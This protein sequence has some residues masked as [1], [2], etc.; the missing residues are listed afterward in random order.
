MKMNDMV[1]VSVDDHITE[2]GNVFDKQLS[3]RPDQRSEAA[4]SNRTAAITGNTRVRKSSRSRST[5][6]LGR[7]REEYGIEPTS[8]EQLRKGC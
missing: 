8:L 3:A 4:R 1:I 2:P 7:V 5:R 6:W